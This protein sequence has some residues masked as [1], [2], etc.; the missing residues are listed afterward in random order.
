MKNNMC[1]P[2]MS[3]TEFREKITK[4]L[5]GDDWFIAFPI[6][7][8]QANTCIYDEIEFKYKRNIFKRNKLWIVLKSLCKIKN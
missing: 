7:Q 6:S 8:E 4:L 2:P 1:P 3:D 5:L